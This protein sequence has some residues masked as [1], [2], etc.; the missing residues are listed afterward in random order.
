M[1]A[2]TIKFQIASILSIQ[3]NNFIGNSHKWL[4]ML[5][6]FGKRRA[7][8]NYARKLPA[9]LKKD[10]G[11]SDKYTVGQVR[12]SIERHRL[13]P[14]YTI[15]A[16]AMFICKNDFQQ[17]D[18]KT[19][20]TYEELRLELTDSYRSFSVSHSEAYIGGNLTDFNDAD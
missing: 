18:Q 5:L 3:E 2:L 1:I 7:I 12:R 14:N 4:I 19:S 20:M 17:L 6:N 16:Y 9:L 15:Y 13:N 10:Y 8:K 11:W